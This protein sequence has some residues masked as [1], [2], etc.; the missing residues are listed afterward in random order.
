MRLIVRT[1]TLSLIALTLAGCRSSQPIAATPGPTSGRSLAEM[2]AEYA[3]LR[4]AHQKKCLSAPPEQVK[5]NQA[6]C[7][8]ER[9]SMAPLGNAIIKAE[10]EAAQRKTKP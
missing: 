9:Q 3:R 10:Q 4:E 7:E 8:Q 6:I 5:A 1:A 2:E